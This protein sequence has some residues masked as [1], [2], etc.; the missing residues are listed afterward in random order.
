MFR[1]S[2]LGDLEVRKAG[3]MCT[4]TAP[5]VRQVLVLLLLR[6]NRLVQVNA[7]I[8]ELWGESPPKSALITAQTYIYQLRKLIKCE[9]LA[10]AGHDLLLTLPTGYRLQIDPAQLDA[11]T[12]AELLGL[13]LHLLEDGQPQAA[14][15]RLHEALALWSGPAFANI[16]RGPL[17]SRHAVHLE[18]QRLRALQ[19]RIR[20]DVQL[21]RERELIG[22]LRSLVATYP[23]NEW[24]HGQLIGAL[25]KAGR[26]DEAVKAYRRVSTVLSRELGIDPSPALQRLHQELLTAGASPVPPLARSGARSER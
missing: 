15:Q 13:G 24:F 6:A 20:A 5:K 16:S 10:P 19:L 23:L 21:C 8:E 22:E 11:C 17:L 3:R 9:Q 26:R 14:S 1:Y 4:P 18:E 25:H 12:F 2:I 7:I